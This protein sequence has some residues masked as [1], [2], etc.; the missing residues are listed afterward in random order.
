[1][2]MADDIGKPKLLQIAELLDRHA[3]EFVQLESLK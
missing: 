1:M 2:S 3:V